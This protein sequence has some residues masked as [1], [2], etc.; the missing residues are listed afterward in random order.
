MPYGRYQY[1]VGP[2]G[3]LATSDAYTQRYDKITE[4]IDQ[5]K[6]C[7]DDSLLY[8]YRLEAAFNKNCNYMTL[9]G[10]NGIIL[11]PEKFVFV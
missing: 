4:H 9:M 8:S 10:K 11:V 1:K 7:V 6:W 3:W 2:R 5:V